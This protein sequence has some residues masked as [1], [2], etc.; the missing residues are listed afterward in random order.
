MRSHDS[1]QLDHEG[2]LGVRRDDPGYAARAVRQVAGDDQLARAADL[3]A[4]HALVPP[5][6]DLPAPEPEG[7]RLLAV[8]A[9]V[10]LGPVGQGTGVVDLD[11]LAGGGFRPGAGARCLRTAGRFRW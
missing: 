1:E 6:D 11:R 3:H 5:V 9:A 8:V 2:Q 10:E 7:E 4:R